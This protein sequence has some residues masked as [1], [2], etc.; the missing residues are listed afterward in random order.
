MTSPVSHALGQATRGFNGLQAKSSLPANT[1]MNPP[2]SW[3]PQFSAVLLALLLLAA[4]RLSAETEYLLHGSTW[5]QDPTE[6]LCIVNTDTGLATPYVAAGTRSIM[7]IAYN[8]FTDRFFATTTFAGTPVSRLIEIDRLSGA[9]LE[10]HQVGLD[11]FSSAEG[12]VA[13]EKSTGL[14][15]SLRS[16]G[17]VHVWNML[18]NT[19]VRAFALPQSNDYSGLIFNAAG[20]LLVIDPNSRAP[21]PADLHRIDK[22][23]GAILET[24]QLSED[25]GVVIGV[26]VHPVTGEAWLSDGCFGD[27]NCTGNR[28]FR[29]DLTTGQLT[30]V[31]N[32]GLPLAGLAFVP[33]E[34]PPGGTAS[35]FDGATEAGTPLAHQQATPL[36]FGTVPR[37][38]AT[39]RPITIK[40]TGSDPLVFNLAGATGGYTL[41]DLPALPATL[42]AGEAVTFNISLLPAS[43]GDIPGMLRIFSND[44][45][46]PLT[47]IPLTAFAQPEKEI[48]I[49][50]PFG[51]LSSGQV[52]TVIFQRNTSLTGLFASFTITNEGLDP[53]TISSV[54]VPA[55]FSAS[56]G[57]PATLT[58]VVNP[59][60]SVNLGIS[61]IGPDPGAYEGI[62]TVFSDDPGISEFTFPIYAVHNK[63]KLQVS[64]VNVGTIF[65]GSSLDF[66]STP[67]G[68]PVGRSF[69]L[70]NLLTPSL[71]IT[72][73]DLPPGFDLQFPP[74]FPVT[75]NLNQSTFITVRMTAAAAGNMQG[76]MVIRTNDFDFPEFE[77]DL[78]G[79]VREES[80][81]FF[82]FSSF[83]D[84]HPNPRVG[85]GA[86]STIS[87]PLTYQ[88]DLDG[89]GEFDDATG[90][91][92]PL[93]GVDGPGEFIA[94]VRISDSRSSKD[95]FGTV[96]INNVRPFLS[97]ELPGTVVAGQPVSFELT[98]SD[99]VADV[100]A[101]F[102]WTVD[103]GDGTTESSDPGQPAV[104]SFS[105]TYVQ[106]GV[107]RSI[108]ITATDKEGAT[109]TF[110]ASPKVQS[111]VIGVFDGVNELFDGEG[112][113]HFF[114]QLGSPED[115]VITLLNRSTAD[116]TVGPVSLP[117]GFVL[118][119]PP[120]FPAT[121]ASGASLDL[122]VRFLANAFGSF[123]GT[124]AI[125]TSD[126]LL[127]VFQ[128]SLT[129]EVESPN[130]SVSNFPMEAFDF[131][132]NSRIFGIQAGTEPFSGSEF[133]IESSGPPL[134]ITGITIPPGFTLIDPPA[135]PLTLDNT[136]TNI[137]IQSTGANPS[138]SKG[139]VIIHSN[140]PADG[141]FTF[142][143]ESRSGTVAEL[144]IVTEEGA[145]SFNN[146][147][148]AEG[149]ILDNQSQPL[150]FTTPG[151]SEQTIRLI[152][153]GNGP[154]SVT[155]AN[156]PV[157]FEFVTPP[158]FPLNLPAFDQTSVTIRFVGTEA[159][160][161]AGNLEWF[162]TDPDESTY[163]VPLLAV[164]EGGEV[165]S[166][167]LAFASL[168]AMIPAD[169]SSG[170]IISASVTGPPNA[171][172][173]LEASTDLGSTDSW[174]VIGQ[175]TLDSNGTGTFTN[176]QDTDSIDATANFFRL[177]T[178]L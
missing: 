1:P 151:P 38:V 99:S 109:G 139:F 119:D 161:Y 22:M 135:F 59:G 28:L 11:A 140:D 55:G 3:L 173:F 143:V 174:E 125:S 164:V 130:I 27:D 159:G 153:R 90:D 32:T 168:P 23:T 70:T 124:M 18:T 169:G 62:V 16:G 31:G 141:E 152:N 100:T 116:A 156:L 33:A 6:S 145:I 52:E 137:R 85:V 165:G 163:R 155:G 172:I 2:R 49:T 76:T 63:P 83:I 94:R 93:P 26:A 53:L 4:T 102:T 136:S 113:F 13:F 149:V 35:L 34:R 69:T 148:T 110:S 144:V 154:L 87:S 25:I 12:D 5:G 123:S 44:P 46:N 8:E 10:T 150:E 78:A 111:G 65:S 40:N 121:L 128:L 133:Q 77:V 9:T 108:F 95:Y 103:W 42:T 134:I 131:E 67:F 98:A 104:R 17:S 81:R 118:V 126:P 71:V 47:E 51:P 166:P 107:Q 30:L 29:L 101:G 64:V 147:F 15:Y 91:L 176:I 86:L 114:R 20:D 14:V 45:T 129:G 92:V 157:G 89:D 43:G 84:E 171:V 37:S 146:F 127:P 80:I 115:R 106:P 79:E 50:G 74:T 54:S 142:Y 19:Y 72:G 21:E 61:S 41:T 7:G 58:R 178:G 158:A 48:R 82:G 36:D 24:I 175:V 56:F 39:L 88:W 117:N 68:G 122:T 60:A 138:A 132:N 105:H 97:G 75:L 66:G 160:T 112:S 96:P 170:A 167:P 177:R 73:I 120:A 57:S 162:S